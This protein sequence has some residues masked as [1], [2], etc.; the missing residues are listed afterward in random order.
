MKALVVGTN[1]GS[2]YLRALKL[3]NDGIN[4]AGILSTGSERSKSYAQ[5]LSIP[6]Y[7]NVSELADNAIDIACVAVQ[8]QAAIDIALALLD[9]KIHVICEHP[10][11]VQQ[12]GLCL[13]KAA[14]KGCVFHV[15]GH[16]AEASACQSFIKAHATAAQQSPCMHYEMSVNLRT[17]YS[18]LDILGRTLGS[19][20]GVEVRPVAKTGQHVF[21]ETVTLVAPAATV[22]LLCQ[23]F[24]SAKDDGTSTLINH[25][26]SAIFSHGNLL[27]AES[28]G[29]VLWFPTPVALP[30]ETWRSSMPVD[31]TSYS[32][33]ELSQ[34]RDYATLG[35]V[36]KLAEQITKGDR[37]VEQEPE[38]LL[39]LARVWEQVLAELNANT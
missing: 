8:G 7:S 24:S 32:Q 12:M 35:S 10:L 27:L 18:A 34:A 3:A 30:P 13:T 15:N 9:K 4:L 1:Y 39:N 33:M 23:N 16:F 36:Y 5:N 14:E 21:F 26:L 11:D 25:R 37:P 20:D 38:Y 19:F 28:N 22:S 31:M 17:L 2:T 6:H 29:P